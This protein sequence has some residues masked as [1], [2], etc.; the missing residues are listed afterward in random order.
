M[1]QANAE[2]RHLAQD[3][4]NALLGVMQRL[5]VAT[6]FLLFAQSRGAAVDAQLVLLGLT[7][8][9]IARSE[10]AAAQ[11][12]SPSSTEELASIGAWIESGRE[13]LQMGSY[14]WALIDFTV[15]VTLAARLLR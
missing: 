15:A 12:A 6:Q 7:G 9:S 14:Q 11:A 5:W 1:T 13:E 8:E 4:A 3:A 2:D 10:W